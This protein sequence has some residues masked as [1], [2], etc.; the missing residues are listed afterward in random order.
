ML[1]AFYFLC[2]TGVYSQDLAQLLHKVAD[3]DGL[4]QKAVHA[5]FQGVAAILVER[6]GSHGKDRELCPGRVIQCADLPGGGIS[7]HL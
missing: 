2:L 7:G 1:R 4:G 6:V 3:H 5:A